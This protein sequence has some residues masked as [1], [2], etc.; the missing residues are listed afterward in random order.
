MT[1]IVRMR[2]TSTG[3]AGTF[4]LRTAS[5]TAFLNGHACLRPLESVEG[6]RR[7]VIR[8]LDYDANIIRMCVS[9]WSDGGCAAVERAGCETCRRDGRAITVGGAL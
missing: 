8:R 5:N 7:H 9:R 6:C 4:P 1:K 2:F 3:P